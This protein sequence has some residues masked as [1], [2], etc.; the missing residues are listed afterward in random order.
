MSF[1]QFSHR[2]GE[3]A[4]FS[5]SS[6][7]W[8]NYDDEQLIN[9]YKNKHRSEI[10]TELHE[11]SS[12]QIKLGNKV[13]SVREIS[14]SV[15]TF[16]FKKY[17]KATDYRDV[18]LFNLRYLPVETYGT[19][20]KFVSDCIDDRMVSEQEI[21]YS[22]KFWGT[23]DAIRFNNGV[24]KVYDLKTGSAPAKFEQV[25]IYAALYCL[26]NNIRP[27]DILTEVRIYQNDEVYIDN[28]D[29]NMILSIMDNIVHKNKVLTKFEGG[30]I[31]A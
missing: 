29:P 24:L 13:S 6:P 14:R 30:Q 8:L 17:E 26:Q 23:T 4:P 28:A 21:G 3:H 25:Y 5:P 2:P 1:P 31:H 20:K 9:A 15:R 16:I 27:F 12:I 18:L 7:S 11:W 19:V 22:D 10:G